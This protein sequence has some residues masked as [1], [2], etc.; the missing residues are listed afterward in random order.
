VPHGLVA[1]EY[2]CDSIHQPCESSARVELRR[3]QT[4]TWQPGWGKLTGRMEK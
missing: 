4:R 2:G 3:L 1:V